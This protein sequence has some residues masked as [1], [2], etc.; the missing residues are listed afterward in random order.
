MLFLLLR[1]CF[2]QDVQM[3]YRN[4]PGY[5]AD[6]K[7]YYQHY[8]IYGKNIVKNQEVKVTYR[9]SGWDTRLCVFEDLTASS[10]KNPVYGIKQNQL[11][12]NGIS[13]NLSLN[14]I[15]DD[16]SSYVQVVYD[17]KNIGNISTKYSLGVTADIMIDTNDRATLNRIGNSSYYRGYKM[18]GNTNTL[19]IY[20]ANT[21]FTT[22][23]DSCW[24]GFYSNRNANIFTNMITKEK[25]DLTNIDSAIALAW[26][27]R[28]LQVGES[29]KHSFIVGIGDSPRNNNPPEISINKYH[30]TIKEKQ[31]TT[32]DITVRDPDSHAKSKISSV[33]MK[34]DNEK[35][36][37]K[38][39]LPPTQQT[40]QYTINTAELNIGI[41]E[42]LVE[43]YCIDDNNDYSN[44]PT[45]RLT[46]ERDYNLNTKPKVSFAIPKTD[47]YRSE[48]MELNF[49]QIDAEN[50]KVSV[51][52]KID[53]EE[54]I[55]VTNSLNSGSSIKFSYSIPDDATYGQH[56]IQAIFTENI[57]SNAQTVTKS[58]SFN[59]NRDYSK[60]QAP[61]LNVNE[62]EEKYYTTSSFNISGTVTDPEGDSVN[63]FIKIGGKEPEE[64]KNIPSGSQFSKS[65]SVKDFPFV[66]G[67]AYSIQ[68]YARDN[69]KENVKE[70]EKI[71]KTLHVC[72]NYE[73][74]TAPKISTNG[75]E[76]E[77]LKNDNIV[78]NVKIDDDQ[79]DNI[80][81]KYQLDNNEEI[82]LFG[83]ENS[84][85][86][87]QITINTNNLD[88]GMH[89]I[90]IVANDLLPSEYQQYQK[91]VTKVIMFYLSNSE[92]TD[93]KPV[94]HTFMLSNDSSY[95]NVKGK[96]VQSEIIEIEFKGSDIDSDDSLTL[97]IHFDGVKEF[98]EPAYENN[99]NIK[100]TRNLASFEKGSHTIKAIL[101]DRYGKFASQEIVFEI[102][103]DLRNNIAPEISN[104]KIEN[105]ILY[106]NSD[107]PFSALLTDQDGDKLSVSISIDGSIVLPKEDVNPGPL[108]RTIP[109]NQNQNYSLGQHTLRIEVKDNFDPSLPPSEHQQYQ[110]SDIKEINFTIY[111]QY[112]DNNKPTLEISEINPEYKFRDTI[113]I[114]GSISDQDNDKVSVYMNF[115]NDG[116][117]LIANNLSSGSNFEYDINLLEK[118]I[119]LGTYG[120]TFYAIDSAFS[121]I[122]KI[123]YSLKSNE[124][125]KT[126]TLVRDFE[127]NLPPT[128]EL[129]STISPIYY[130][131]ESIQFEGY[132]TDPEGDNC[133]LYMIIDQNETINIK[134]TTSDDNHF[135]YFMNLSIFEDELQYHKIVFYAH[136]GHNTSEEYLLVFMI[137]KLPEPTPTASIPLPTRTLRPIHVDP[138]ANAGE[139]SAEKE[140]HD[141]LVLSITIAVAIIAILSTVAV[142]LSKHTNKDD[143]VE[144]E[145]VN[146]N[147]AEE[148]EQDA[149]VDYQNPLYNCS[150]TIDK[151]DPFADDFEEDVFDSYEYYNNRYSYSDDMTFSSSDI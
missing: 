37:I 116:Y 99:T 34:I 144:E 104:E 29:T 108:S 57:I 100:R 86:T 7:N 136:D 123:D 89:T 127:V 137:Q 128:V 150:D 76:S 126:F 59:V 70:S 102:I 30:E 146:Y 51:H 8:D 65:Y 63:V 27:G 31:S 135:Q 80:T 130:N 22:N 19:Y 91:S 139:N 90:S 72:R 9:N 107:I 92:S 82:V 44:N 2:S 60:N 98:D 11:V 96:Y 66:E 69:V 85:T 140:K 114:S 71:E 106:P 79:T 148:F 83:N 110:K 103:R 78:I 43:F 81:C 101:K 109:H 111:R 41:G 14:I 54:P 13:V 48:T 94:I 5:S 105:S 58:Y 52:Y 149:T 32:I 77:Y 62:I 39:D 46:V 132:V 61:I 26:Q 64:L 25:A 74:N 84:G 12:K 93:S 10:C 129:D 56:T 124:I 3:F 119:G 113:H 125:I 112:K 142:V 33:Y 145:E 55:L 118:S 68:V 75:E 23:I 28:V 17:V 147:G 134:N 35:T 50:D 115:N 45:L 97:E 122:E 15:N 38:K 120:I 53:D 131:I 21:P 49:G 47:F 121:E 141:R 143:I 87:K 42:H 67:G 138:N 36:L 20:F 18:T 95:T 1:L 24:V 117:E 40:F 73:I 88:I 4:P 133:S 16:S 6:N 151:S